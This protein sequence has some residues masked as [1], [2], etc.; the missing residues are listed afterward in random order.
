VPGIG[1]TSARRIVGSRRAGRIR[2]EDLP[3]LGVVMRRARWFLTLYGKSLAESRSP[4]APSPERL[5]ARIADGGHPEGA[6][7]DGSED[8][9]KRGKGR[10]GRAAASG[11]VGGQLEFAFP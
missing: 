1:V 8:S 7:V 3:R 6:E 9:G 4:E 5:R 11:A 2:A 10:G